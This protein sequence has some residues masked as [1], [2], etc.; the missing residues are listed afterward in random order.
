MLKTEYK[1]NL[2]I[3]DK[4]FLL[5]VKDPDLKDKKALEIK[6]N[7]QKEELE[8]LDKQRLKFEEN[9]KEIEYKQ[10][11]L[12][13]N[14]ELLSDPNFATKTEILLENKN[15]IK[16]INS[17]KKELKEPNYDNLSKKLEE[18]L[19]Y[20]SRLLISGEQKEEFLN[21]VANKAISHK[22]IWEE[23]SNGVKVA[24]QKKLQN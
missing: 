21:V 17:L 6:T 4:E 11:I 14:E 8:K 1:V 9:L 16:E 3:D 19:E 18:L 7:E 5:T 13:V 2:Q 20:K 10:R 15:L 12:N 24:T 22:L 23:I